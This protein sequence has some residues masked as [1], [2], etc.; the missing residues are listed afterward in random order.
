[1]VNLKSANLKLDLYEFIAKTLVA[2]YLKLLTY[3]FTVSIKLLKF[4]KMRENYLINYT[5][6]MVHFFTWLV[7]LFTNSSIN[8]DRS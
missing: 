8:I 5:F 1:M 6:N 4:I 2:F 3:K 7:V